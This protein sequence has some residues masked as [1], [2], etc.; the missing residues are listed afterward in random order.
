MTRTL[1]RSFASAALWV[2][3]AASSAVAADAP[4]FVYVSVAGENRIAVMKQDA[5]TGRLTHQ[6][7]GK[8]ESGPGSLA[9]SPNKSRLYAA[10]RGT[11]SVVSL[12]VDQKTGALKTLGTTPV[13]DNPVYV[14]TDRTGRWLLA[15]SYSAGKFAIYPI[16][17]NGVVGAKASQLVEAEKNAHAIRIDAANEFVYVPNCGADSLLVYRFNPENGTVAPA[18]TPRVATA[19]RSGPRHLAFHPTQP[20]IY[21]VN[22]HDS[23]AS[24]FKFDRATETLSPI[25]TLSTLPKSF[26]GKN[27]CADAEVS[28][29]GKTFY[30]SNRGRDSIAI[31]AIDPQTGAL[32]ARGDAATGKTPREFG[33]DPA[34]KFLYSAGQGDGSLTSHKIAADG[35]LEKLTVE[36]I[37]PDPCWVLATTLE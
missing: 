6:S 35:S 30:G 16:D 26:E 12:A 3:L 4:V 8:I 9:L 1:S 34:G 19:Q 24:A 10:A 13:F 33:L 15:A 22:E 5:E 29:D 2:A 27:T 23:T 11:K 17:A 21:V 18:K 20:W 28:P 37:G 32:T 36:Q 7:D 31:Y 25:N 14:T